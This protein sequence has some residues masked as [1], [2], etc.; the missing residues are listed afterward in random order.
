MAGGEQIAI[1]KLIAQ[2]AA[3]THAPT[4][5]VKRGHLR[6]IGQFKVVIFDHEVLFELLI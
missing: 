5:G 3:I 4:G 1:E 2:N 6:H